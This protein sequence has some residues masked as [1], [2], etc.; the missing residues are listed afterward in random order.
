MQI[1]ERRPIPCACLARQQGC[2]RGALPVS[3]QLSH[4]VCTLGGHMS[5]VA[6]PT[7]DIGATISVPLTRNLNARVCAAVL[8]TPAEGLCCTQATLDTLDDSAAEWQTTL[9]SSCYP[10]YLRFRCAAACSRQ[11]PQWWDSTISRAHLCPAYCSDLWSYCY[12]PGAAQAAQAHLRSEAGFCQFNT[13]VGRANASACLGHLGTSPSGTPPANSVAV[14]SLLAPSPPPRPP[15]PPPPPPQA[16][17]TASPPP[18]AGDGLSGILVAGIVLGGCVLVLA[19][20]IWRGYGRGA[21]RQQSLEAQARAQASANAQKYGR[22]AQPQQQ[23]QQQQRAGGGDEDAQC[24][25]PRG[26]TRGPTRGNG[27]GVASTEA[28]PLLRGDGKSPSRRRSASAPACTPSLMRSSTRR[29]APA[30]RPTSTP[31]HGSRPRAVGGVRHG[32][33]RRALQ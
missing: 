6:N 22:P 16:T 26:L 15:R 17:A 18:P 21:A 10:M 9:T 27:G 30:S 1:N 23:Q 24:C 25:T 7:C 28:T 29:G 2:S 5:I 4:R 20:Y 12:A 13:G 8:E 19:V 11:L 31:R 33:A 3:W 14:N 32:R